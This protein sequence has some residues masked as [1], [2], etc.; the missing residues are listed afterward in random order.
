MATSSANPPFDKLPAELLL[1]VVGYLDVRDLLQLSQTTRSICAFIRTHETSL[2]KPFISA[3][4][5]R[6]RF[7]LDALNFAGLEII[8]AL[9]QF[10]SVLDTS[11]P[12][13]NTFVQ[14]CFAKYYSHPSN[15]KAKQYSYMELRELAWM[16][17]I[18]ASRNGPFIHMMN[19]YF[20]HI[21]A[22]IQAV[23]LAVQEKPF[24]PS[25]VIWG[26]DYRNGPSAFVLLD[27]SLVSFLE[28]P[29]PT[30]GKAYVCRKSE[31]FTPLWEP[32]QK[33]IASTK[34][35]QYPGA[36]LMNARMLKLVQILPAVARSDWYGM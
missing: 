21:L 6:V 26:H 22:E 9:R 3:Q 29:G 17:M 30:P 16:T 11:R 34:K 32:V 1:V 36:E 2:A 31:T 12:L 18:T 23:Q 14:D 15:P 35:A 10:S 19:I 7:Q 5:E 33:S 8:P 13:D 20:P 27:Q 25:T 4:Q 28:L 24:W